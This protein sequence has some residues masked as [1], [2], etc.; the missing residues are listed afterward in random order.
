[1][2]GPAAGRTVPFP[3]HVC[4]ADGVV[5]DQQRDQWYGMPEIGNSL[6]CP[7]CGG[8]MEF[9]PKEPPVRIFFCYQCG[10]TFDKMG[11]QWFGLSA[12]QRP[13]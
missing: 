12:H 6:N 11:G 4:A 2:A 8:G 3:M 1:M 10:T 7:A 13:P 9:E 5:Y